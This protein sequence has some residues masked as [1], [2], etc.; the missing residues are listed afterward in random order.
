[1]SEGV[2]DWLRVSLSSVLILAGLGKLRSLRE[3]AT[4]IRTLTSTTF[5]CGLVLALAVSTTEVLLAL[6][7]VAP[8]AVGVAG[9]ATIALVAIFTVTLVFAARRA[10]SCGCFGSRTANPSLSKHI[11]LNACLFGAAV[12][13]A[14]RYVGDGWR[15]PNPIGPFAFAIWLAL[16]ATVLSV[17]YV[18]THL[19][20]MTAQSQ[21]QRRTML[22]PRN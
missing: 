10:E 19:G 8:Y 17:S 14:T 21:G 16:V 1:M 7:L 13:V 18:R 4:T 20:R 3:F 5:A 11:A 12:F 2:A 22:L 6:A 15:Q 9:T